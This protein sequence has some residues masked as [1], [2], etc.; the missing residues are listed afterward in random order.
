MRLACWQVRWKKPNK[1]TRYRGGGRQYTEKGKK[2][3][4]KKNNSGG[5]WKENW[6]QKRRPINACNTRKE[7]THMGILFIFTLIERFAVKSLNYLY[8]GKFYSSICTSVHDR[9]VARQS[10]TWGRSYKAGLG[11]I[12]TTSGL[13]LSSVMRLASPVLKNSRPNLFNRVCLRYEIHA[14]W[15]FN[16]F[17]QFSG[18]IF[19]K[20]KINKQKKKV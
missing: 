2:R 4:K 1:S 5:R 18:K 7:H 14:Y 11:L 15:Q 16:Q 19:G 17:N 9:R 10:D 3:K 12:N 13:T 20:T 6:Y 8:S